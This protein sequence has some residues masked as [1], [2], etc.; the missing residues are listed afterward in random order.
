MATN[1]V[2][3]EVAKV[4]SA[5]KSDIASIQSAESK[6]SRTKLAWISAAVGFIAYPII[7]F[8]IKAIL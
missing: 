3:Q 2:Q 7:V 5:V 8:I 1:Q 6:L 4:E